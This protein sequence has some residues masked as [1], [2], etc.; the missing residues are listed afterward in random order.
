MSRYRSIIGSNETVP[1][2]INVS[3]ELKDGIKAF[4]TSDTPRE[5]GGVL[6]GKFLKTILIVGR[7]W[8]KII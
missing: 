3:E 1:V 5:L 6:V 8:L 4:S 7:L 2:Q